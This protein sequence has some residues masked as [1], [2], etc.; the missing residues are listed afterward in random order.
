MAI[1]KPAGTWTY[2]DLFSLPSDGKRYEIIEGELYETPS[3]TRAH[4]RV[5]INLIALLLPIAAR[6]RGQLFTAPLDVFVPGGDPVQPDLILLLPDT[7]ARV[8]MRGVVGAPNLIV[9]IISPSNRGHDQLTKRA[10]YA[11]AGV[12]EYWIVDPTARTVDVLAL[13]RDALHTVQTAA[14]DDVV[15]S[16]RRDGAA[17][18]LTSVF[19][20]LE[21]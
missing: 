5:I 12:Q 18:P 14:G 4:A 3:S 13:D 1:T 7:A 20:N 6:L 19:A 2:D 11:R 9:E 15:V 17:F 10:L 21:S 16:P 8:E